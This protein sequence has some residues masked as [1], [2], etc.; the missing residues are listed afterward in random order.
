[1]GTSIMNIQLPESQLTRIADD[2]I[3]IDDFVPEVITNILMEKVW[4]FDW[5]WFYLQDTTYRDK[6]NDANKPTWDDG[7]STLLYVRA[8]PG[9]DGHEGPGKDKPFIYKAQQYYDDVYPILSHMEFTLGLPMETLKRV[10]TNLN[11]T[12]P[13]STPF[14]PHIDVTKYQTWTG[15]LCLNDSDGPTVIYNQKKPKDILTAR[16]A[17]D[18]YREHKDEFEILCEVQPKKGRFVLFD[19]DYY[20]SGTRPSQHKNRVNLNINWYKEMP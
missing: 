11:T 16:G 4:R 6:Y 12:A 19:G 15:L 2:I 20:H 5:P 13:T 1:M 3:V 18:W 7:F 10:K 17:L 9:D 14:E 8:E